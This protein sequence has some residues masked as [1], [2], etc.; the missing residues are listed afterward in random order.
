MKKI[1][2]AIY[3]LDG[4]ILNSGREGFKRLGILA[5]KNSILFTKE[6]QDRLEENWGFSPIRL[7]A[8]GFNVSEDVAKDLH[9]QWVEWDEREP[10]PLVEGIKERL[11][12]NLEN[13]IVNFIFTSRHTESAFNVI[14]KNNITH[15]FEDIVGIEGGVHFNE[16]DMQYIE[17]TGYEKPNPRALDNLLAFIKDFFGFE[18]DEVAYIGDEIFDVQCG[19]GA[20][21]QTFAVLSG[22]KRF[23]RLKMTGISEKRI[24]KNAT[25]I[26]F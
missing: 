1:K 18:R 9:K 13:G 7:I 21:L 19:T 11:E 3:D 25:D 26:I 12:N 8:V 14:Q 15:L 6:V 22:L 24:Y 2:V 4:T 16:L 20:G 10:I 17:A 5:E 23:E